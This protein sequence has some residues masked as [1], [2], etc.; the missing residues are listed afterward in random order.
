MSEKET[1][2]RHDKA[3]QGMDQ[4]SGY[5]RGR[6]TVPSTLAVA[7]SSQDP[8]K[9]NNQSSEGKR[10]TEVDEISGMNRLLKSLYGLNNR[11]SYLVS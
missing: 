9:K 10:E 8:I 4:Q 7:A 11:R 5:W 3:E 2:I 6:Q 1:L